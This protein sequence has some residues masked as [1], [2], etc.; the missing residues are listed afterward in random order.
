MLD[1]YFQEVDIASGQV[2]FQ[3]Q[4]SQ[5]VALNESYQAPPSGSQPYDFFHINSIEPDSDGNLIIS[6]RH[7]WAVYKINRSTGDVIWRLNGKLSDFAMGSQARFAYQH[8]ARSH[9]GNVLSIFDDGGGATNVET[10]SRGLVLALNLVAKQARMVRSYYPDPSFVT[11]SQGNVQ[12]LVDGNAFLGWGEKPYFSEYGGHGPAAV[13]GQALSGRLLPGVPL[14]LDGPP[15]ARPVHRRPTRSGRGHRPR[16]LE[17]RHR[18]GEVGGSCGS[19]ERGAAAGRDL[20]PG[21]VRDHPPGRDP[22]RPR[23]RASDGCQRQGAR[24]LPHRRRMSGQNSDPRVNHQD[25][26]RSGS[27]VFHT[28][29]AV[30]HELGQHPVAVT[31]SIRAVSRSR[32]APR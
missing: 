20:Q 22:R 13:R 26:A 30:T 6:A 24:S 27:L 7:T 2:L 1:S 31:R 14:S 8:D 15:P 23:R 28:D 29:V 12:L 32:R 17:R 18:R 5:H 10:R 3:W 16:Q 4:A 19:V 25:P 11:T 9:P 21:R